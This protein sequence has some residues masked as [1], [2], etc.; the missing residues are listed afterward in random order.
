M[1]KQQSAMRKIALTTSVTLMVVGL[2]TKNPLSSRAAGNA[3]DEF[4]HPY[5]NAH[6]CP[7]GWLLDY[8]IECDWSN[9]DGCTPY[10]CYVDDPTEC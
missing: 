10:R 8:H 7:G 2:C 4:G 3:A 6:T 5:I 9:D 1:T